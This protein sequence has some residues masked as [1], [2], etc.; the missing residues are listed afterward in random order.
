M[1][2]SKIRKSIRH[3]ANK[4]ILILIG[5]ISMFF[6]LVLYITKYIKNNY[7]A[8]AD[9]TTD[10]DYADSPD[11][12]EKTGK[13]VDN[14]LGMISGEI[15]LSALDRS[16][17]IL[18]I[19]EC[20]VYQYYNEYGEAEDEYY[21]TIE[22]ARGYS[23][24]YMEKL[25]GQ[26]LEEMLYSP[27]IDG[28]Y[29]TDNNKIHSL[30]DYY[31][32]SYED[33]IGE[34]EYIRIST[35]DY[36]TLIKYYGFNG[37]QYIYDAYEYM[38]SPYMDGVSENDTV[39]EN[40][41]C[42]FV[43][44]SD[45]M[46]KKDRFDRVYLTD[47]RVIYENEYIYIPESYVYEAINENI[48][49]DE[50]L[51]Y[52]PI[53]DNR[54]FALYTALED[55]YYT[56]SRY[57][58]GMNSEYQVT[59][60]YVYL[61]RYGVYGDVYYYGN[62][63]M[64]TD[65]DKSESYEE[66][67]ASIVDDYDMVISSHTFS[68][69]DS[70]YSF[71][72]DSDGQKHITTY[73]V[74]E[75]LEK[76]NITDDNFKFII[77]LNTG[78]K[79][80][81]SMSLQI[82][83]RLY[84]DFCKIFCPH[85]YLAF[86]AAAVLYS[87]SMI[88][89]WF[90]VKKYK[91]DGRSGKMYLMDKAVIEI[92]I[93]VWLFALFI[94]YKSCKPFF[95]DVIQY[96]SY[97]GSLTDVRKVIIVMFYTVLYFSGMSIYCSIIRRVKRKVLVDELASVRLIKWVNGMFEMASRQGR[98]GKV[99]FIR[100]SIVLVVNIAALIITQV[101]DI[102]PGVVILIDIGFI[103]VNL[104]S[105]SKTVRNE[106]GVDR[107]L[108]TAKEIGGGNLDAQVDTEGISGSSLTLAQTINGMNYALNEAVE[109]NVRDERMKA[110][111]VT[112]VSHDIKTPLTSIINYVGLIK[113]E[114]VH[115]EK[116][117]NYVDILESKSQRLKQLI[118]DLIE[119]SRAS[120]GEIELN[121]IRLDFAELLNQVEGENI[122]RFENKGL[123]IVSVISKKSV[124]I[125]ADGRHLFRITENVLNNAYKYSKEGSKVYLALVSDGNE[126]IMTLENTSFRPITESPEELMERFVRGDKS[127]STEGSGLGLSIAKSL[128]ELMKGKF[129]IEI[130]EDNFKV[131]IRFPLAHDETSETDSKQ[132]EA[133]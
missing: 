39:I 26:T 62:D 47:N 75:A 78:V 109:K 11:V 59:D 87:A 18:V 3:S 91:Y 33:F 51:L 95:S 52:A 35:D 42:L 67:A 66:K 1:K 15:G 48:D 99:A 101:F 122:D 116:L 110:E 30:Y 31:N 124:M 113:R 104:L 69:T 133:S 28:T 125:N 76:Y 126:A 71:Y 70:E 32:Y 24:E 34:K 61:Y 79:D 19:D 64:N 129:M 29:I 90:A 37:G 107:V 16:Q 117:L 36:L 93:L 56:M 38:L 44:N 127:R 74:K 17:D 21:T 8:T 105:L 50:A 41:G 96:D 58:Y 94:A 7:F 27:L 25:Y 83:N 120:S 68:D 10:S 22:T 123:E 13:Y 103:L 98:G 112:N 4:V 77:G 130:K 128:T 54:K 100:G 88:L 5:F 86:A 72:T 60:E 14:I 2:D 80:D 108:N 12:R 97:E 115:N 118:E 43:M 119:A 57:I 9:I 111:L 20:K 6:L 131:T 53:L 49:F 114:E 73:N 85:Y 65:F 23:V 89:L 82:K 121:V 45:V 46:F 92:P 55:Y 132:P 81:G 63:S 102:N 84:Y 40:D 106:E